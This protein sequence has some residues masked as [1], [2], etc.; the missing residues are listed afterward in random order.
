VQKS[1]A[2]C[3]EMM[4]VI[5]GVPI[6]PIAA[7]IVAGANLACGRMCQPVDFS[8]TLYDYGPEAR[9]SKGRTLRGPETGAP[10]ETLWVR[11]A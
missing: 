4:Y 10:R 2:F 9:A 5:V 8:Y 3:P 7:L 6:I 1:A 11:S